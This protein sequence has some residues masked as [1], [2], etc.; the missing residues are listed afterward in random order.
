MCCVFCLQDAEVNWQF[1]I[2]AFADATPGHTLS[3]LTFHLFKQ[4]GLL[5]EFSVDQA[6]FWNFL[7]KVESGYKAENPYHNR[8]DE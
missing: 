8:F 2:F 5:N 6:K 7:Q 1:N 4:A 3:V